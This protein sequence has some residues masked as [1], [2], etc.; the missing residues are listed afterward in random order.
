MKTF[1]CTAVSAFV[2]VV[3]PIAAQADVTDVQHRIHASSNVD[4]YLDFDLGHSVVN[5]T[6]QN[7]ASHVLA[8]GDGNGGFRVVD[9]YEISGGA[10]PSANLWFNN[11]T[12]W[13]SSFQGYVGL[14]PLIGK[15]LKTVRFAPNRP[16]LES[17][18]RFKSA[19]M[20]AK[21]LM[22]WRQGDQATFATNGGIAFSLGVSAGIAVATATVM[23]DGEHE[24]SVEKNDEHS[25]SVSLSSTHVKSAAISVG[26]SFATLAQSKAWSLEHGLSFVVDTSTDRGA[27]AYED[28]VRGNVAV[29]QA[30][31]DAGELSEVQRAEKYQTRQI[32]RYRSFSVG[33][34]FMW[35]WSWSSGKLTKFN[36]TYLFDGGTDVQTSYG[37]YVKDQTFQTI[38]HHHSTAAGFYGASFNSTSEKEKMTGKFGQFYW[39][40]S[41]DHSNSKELR[42]SLARL[43]RA[44]G[45]GAD[46]MVEVPDEA[47]GTNMLSLAVDITDAQTDILLDTVKHQAKRDFEAV[48]EKHLESYFASGDREKLCESASSSASSSRSEAADAQASECVDQFK[49][50]SAAGADEMYKALVEMN[51]VRLPRQPEAFTAAFAKFGRGMMRNQFTFQAALQIAGPGSPLDYKVQGTTFANYHVSFETT[52]R[53]DVLK[54]VAPASPNF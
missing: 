38:D 14:F 23:V 36:D 40:F 19:P 32:A 43:L 34:P 49:R 5:L 4:F 13:R 29:I 47:V 7:P 18:S 53:S 44:T 31:M 2:A 28:L 45:F 21:D 11:G 15:T 50:E 33:L 42:H 30:R 39:A 25:Y 17:M 6:P 22:T 1:L 37:I 35:L 3:T 20:H 24:L 26:A 10:G 48:T 16:S 46:L 12:G 8:P 41:S 27:H 52:A 51:E 9:F 54:S